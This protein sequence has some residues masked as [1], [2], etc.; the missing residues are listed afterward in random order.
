MR[1]V[2]LI[3]IFII[4]LTFA[5]CSVK[6]YYFPISEL[7]NG[8]VYKYECKSEPSKT[9]YWKLTSDLKNQILTTEA[10]ESDFRQYELFKEKITDKGTEVIEF[11]SYLKN[12]KGLLLP[13]YNIPK[14]VDVFKWNKKEPYKYSAETDYDGKYKTIFSKE[15]E[16]VGEYLKS[17]F[18]EKNTKQLN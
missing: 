3:S 18:S 6:E 11:T 12:Q 16:Y 13:V 8:K 4:I 2:K 9:Q 10:Y 17:I 7:T 1:Y 15:R 14:D 5:G